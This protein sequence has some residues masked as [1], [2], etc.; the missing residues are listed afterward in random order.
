MAEDLSHP[1]M[2]IIYYK[3]LKL[4]A[5][6]IGGYPVYETIWGLGGKM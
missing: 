5:Y 6:I 2:R 4:I 1:K 3:H